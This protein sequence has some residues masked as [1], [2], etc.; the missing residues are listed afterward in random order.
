[1]AVDN[2]TATGRLP[3]AAGAPALRP[4]GYWASVWTRFKRDRVALVAAGVLAGIVLACFVGEPVAAHFLGHTADEP[5]PYATDANLAPVG[6]LSSVPDQNS[7]YP[8][9]T[10]ET[11]HTFFLLGADGPLGRDELLRLLRGGQVSL[12]VALGATLVAL[13]IGVTLGMVGGFFGG[14]TDTVVTTT[15][16]F[17]MAF[18]LFLLV[19]AIG[20]TIADR[21][22]SITLH[23]TFEPGVLSLALVI[24]VFLFFYPARI[25]RSRIL[26]L[27]E[28]EFVDAARVTGASNRRILVRHILPHLVGPMV[29]WS[30]LVAATVIILEASLSF[31]NFGIRLPTASWGNL[32]AANWGTLLSFSGQAPTTRSGWTMALPAVC[33]LVTV[34]SLTLVGDGLRAAFDPKEEGGG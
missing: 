26:T 20:Q 13:L 22:D 25:V 12:E 2:G 18:P 30:T 19:I 4:R 33:V 16:E 14:F 8:Q 10:A 6:P 9:P 29:V 23:G 11:P 15:T 24:G 7:A 5:F 27:R 17:V 21:F 3:P 1:M 32:L 28:Q 34:L 31:F